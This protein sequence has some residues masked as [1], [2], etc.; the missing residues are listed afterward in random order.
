MRFSARSLGQGALFLMCLN[1]MSGAGVFVNARPL[2]LLAGQFGFLSYLVGMAVM[3]PVVLALSGMAQSNPVAGGLYIYAKDF[4][5]KAFG[6]LSGWS[7]FLA[8]SVSAAVLIQAFTVPVTILLQPYIPIKRFILDFLILTSIV[9]SNS[10]GV[11]LGGKVQ[12]LFVFVKA[13][14]YG[15]IILGGLTLALKSQSLSGLSEFGLGK[16]IWASFPVAIF[17]ISGF[18]I[19]CTM[20]HMIKNPERTIRRVALMSFFSVG[21][22]YSAFQIFAQISA[23]PE[24]ATTATPFLFMSRKLT[25]ILGSW[26][27]FTDEFMR[28][29]TITIAF[30]MLTNNCWNLYAIAKDGLLP[31]SNQLTKVNSND[32]PWVCLVVEALLSF[33]VMAITSNQIALQS[34]TVFSTCLAYAISTLAAFF[35]SMQQQTGVIEKLVCL[36]AV[37]SCC[38]IVG[39]STLNIVQSGLS[40]SFMCIFAS[41]IVIAATK[42]LLSKAI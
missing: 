22:L 29:S 38:L 1:S 4:L 34:M 15:A 41:G 5:G 6:F 18:E 27:S 26:A 10:I 3:F 23:G 12:W 31:F 42:K 39:L 24:L 13:L 19:T 9:I 33:M 17:A 20:A 2:S 36:A 37:G 35:Y 8:K 25:A 28:I 14:P 32:V 16:N 40:L 30:S 11:R 21:F 7:Y